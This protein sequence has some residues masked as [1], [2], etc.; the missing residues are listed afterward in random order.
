MTTPEPPQ[1]ATATHPA[2]HLFFGPEGLRAGWSLLLFFALLFV[3]GGAANRAARLLHPSQPHAAQHELPPGASLL[4]ETVPFLVITLSTLIMARVERRPIAAFGLGRTPRALPQ[5]LSGLALG[6]LLLAILCTTLWL[7]HLLVFTGTLLS[8]AALLRFAA[9]WAAAFLLVGLF[10]EYA[11]RGYLQF[12]L[13]RGLGA[14]LHLVTASPYAKA[15][16]FWSAAAIFSF[17]FGFGHKGNAGESPIGLLS[18]GLIGLVFCL[19]LWRTGSL[20]WAVGFHAAWD[21]TQSF[22]FGVADSGTL[23]RFHLLA[24]HPQG[25]PL[26]SGGTTGPEGSLFVLP[27]ILLITLAIPLTLRHTGWLATSP[28][29]LPPAGPAIDRSTP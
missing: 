2:H 9:E 15:I 28:H 25:A 18:A 17:I 19:S 4:R 23:I 22:V 3:L 21:W 11:L 5:F 26:L 27:T 8:G 7:T 12:T 14:L 29:P 10:E 24:S 1:H 16:G 20:W 13:A 6:A